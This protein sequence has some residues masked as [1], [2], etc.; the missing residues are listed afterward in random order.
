MI[1]FENAT[2]LFTADKLMDIYSSE[3][4]IRSYVLASWYNH[5]TSI[6]IEDI[7]NDH[8]NVLPAPGKIKKIDFFIRNRPFDL[9]VTY[10]PEGY[11]KEIRKAQSKASELTLLK[12]QAKSLG[13]PFE[14][15]ASESFLLQD[16][17]KKL[18]DHPDR[19]AKK[20]LDA[21]HKDRIQILDDCISSPSVLMTWLYENQGVRR[22]DASYRLFLVLV[23]KTCFFKSWEIKRAKD[24]IKTHVHNNLDN[25]SKNPGTDIKFSW[26]GKPYSTVAETIFVVK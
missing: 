21:L 15:T 8:K 7:F 23:N 5:W 11:I 13:L 14:K 22:F 12:S 19:Q 17:W 16:L 20:L 24:L 2:K 25:V 1:S 4:G 6:I 10:L 18:S 26:E 9:K 3:G